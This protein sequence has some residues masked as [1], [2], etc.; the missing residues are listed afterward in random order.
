MTAIH[1]SQSFENWKSNFR[2]LAIVEGIS[3][4]I[5]D[6]SLS[7]IKPDPVVLKLDGSQPEFTRNIWDYL[8]NAISINRLKKGRSLLNKYK[9]LFD[10]IEHRY[11]VDREIIVAIWATESDFGRNY[12]D[13][14]VLRSLATLAFGSQSRKRSLFAQDELLNALKII[15]GRKVDAGNLVGSWAGA[16]GQPQFMPSSFLKYAQDYNNDGRID[17]WQNVADVFAS[18]ANFLAES[19]WRKGERWGVEVKLPNDFDWRLNSSDYELRFEQWHELGVRRIDGSA[20]ENPQRLSSLFIPAGKD[21]PVF[22]VTHNFDVIKKYNKSQSYAL[23]VSHLG[24]RF[25]DGKAF[26]KSWPRSDPALSRQQIETLQYQLLSAGHSPGEIDGKIGSK[27]REAIRTWQL[28]HG[29]PGDGYANFALLSLIN[30][31]TKE[32]LSIMQNANE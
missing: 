26:V 11:A 12:G 23:A 10:Q 28:E 3:P 16:M 8:D 22:L 6:Q 17:L 19:G 30:Q 13:L 2:V 7:S 1:A 24:Q 32:T 4:N 5:V 15:Q 20:Y 21:G 14:N 27:T 25:K 31:K 9:A 18:M 29:L